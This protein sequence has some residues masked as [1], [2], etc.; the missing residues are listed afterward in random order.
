MYEIE[1]VI[2]INQQENYSWAGVSYENNLNIV[3]KGS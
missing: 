1:V 3:N 2:I